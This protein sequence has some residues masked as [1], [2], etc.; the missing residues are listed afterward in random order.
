MTVLTDQTKPG[1]FC[2]SCSIIP[3]IVVFILLVPHPGKIKHV[4]LELVLAEVWGLSIHK[5]NRKTQIKA[6]VMSSGNTE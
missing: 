5:R 1:F 4:S 6:S 2:A 3:L